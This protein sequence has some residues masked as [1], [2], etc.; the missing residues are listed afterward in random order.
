MVVSDV[1][2][3]SKGLEKDWKYWK[4]EKESRPFKLQEYLKVSKKP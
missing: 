2:T 1:G 3:V 4:S